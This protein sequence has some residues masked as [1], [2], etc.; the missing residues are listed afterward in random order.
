MSSSL[1]LKSRLRVEEVLLSTSHVDDFRAAV[2]VLAQSYTLDTVVRVGDTWLA[3]DDTPSLA[4]SVVAL[5]AHAREHAGPHE[6]VASESHA[7]SV[8]SRA[9]ACDGDAGKLAA[10][11]Q[12]GVV[13]RRHGWLGSKRAPDEK[14]V[15][16]SVAV[17][18]G[19]RRVGDW[20]RGVYRVVHMTTVVHLLIS[21]KPSG[22]ICFRTP[23][24]QQLGFRAR[25]EG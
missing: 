8:V 19:R 16:A 6:A 23:N 7:L 4:A 12:V 10:L 24:S 11:L 25:G 22:K 2:P 3:R 5:V 21:K 20:R 14:S 13:L 1:R 18:G 17:G 15:R 9:D